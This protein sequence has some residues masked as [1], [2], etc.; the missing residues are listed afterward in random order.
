MI[1][2]PG[3]HPTK[4]TLRES[5]ECTRQNYDDVVQ[6]RLH[7][8]RGLEEQRRIVNQLEADLSVA[9]EKLEKKQ[10]RNDRYYLI[11][12]ELK[13]GCKPFI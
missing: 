5:R 4:R 10:E 13:V 3:L 1:S 12:L 2:N 6:K 7:I 8:K 9:K 11:E